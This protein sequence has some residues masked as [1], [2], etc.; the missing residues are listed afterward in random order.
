MDK[1]HYIDKN[2]IITIKRA[3][4]KSLYFKEIKLVILRP[5]TP[6]NI[7]WA[8]MG[9]GFFWKKTIRSLF[10]TLSLGIL[11]VSFLLIR[12][13]NNYRY[14]YIHTHQISYLTRIVF[15]GCITSVIMFFNWVLNQFIIH[16]IRFEFHS[17][18]TR[19]YSNIIK[20]MVLKMFLNTTIMIFLLSIDKGGVDQQFFIFQLFVYN[21]ATVL[22]APYLSFYDFMYFFKIFLRYRIRKQQVW[23]CT[24]EYL[25]WVYENPEY[26]IVLHFSL[27]VFHLFHLIFYVNFYPF[28]VILEIALYHVQNYFVQKYLFISRNSTINDFRFELNDEVMNLIDFTPSVVLLAQALKKIFVTKD[29]VFT[30][31]FIAKMILAIWTMSFPNEKLIR[32]LFISRQ[33]NYGD[34]EQHKHLFKKSNYWSFNPAYAKVRGDFYVH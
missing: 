16:T 28:W 7:N 21:T 9:V 29:A 11:L 15:N 14:E 3:P 17:K 5:P 30:G 20:K 10:F 22:F 26:T 33:K 6:N 8:Y 25:N 34:I 2:Q 13:F 32:Y 18:Q 31:W 4:N 12:R 19:G 23:T 27:F 1:D 24:Q